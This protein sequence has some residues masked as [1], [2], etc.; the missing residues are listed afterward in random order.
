[1]RRLFAPE[2]AF[3]GLTPG[4]TWEAS[5]A[6]DVVD[7]VILGRWFSPDRRI[8][9]VLDLEA[10]QV[11]GLDHVRYR[12]AVDRPDG[13]FVVEQQAYYET[14]GGRISSMRVLCSG[15]LPATRSQNE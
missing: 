15:Y 9:R 7:K 11:G 2:I 6:D 1:M 4:G 5:G 8:T 13:S 3:F 14:S 12:F 10:T